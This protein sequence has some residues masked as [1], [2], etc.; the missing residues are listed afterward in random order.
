MK[1]LTDDTFVDAISAAQFAV[2]DFWAPWCGPCRMISPILEELSKVYQNISFFKV[3][4]D[5]N[6]KTASYF[7]IRSIPL[8]ILFKNG[9]PQKSILGARPKSVYVSEFNSLLG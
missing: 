9:Q 1:E 7:A 8:V 5:L 6:P 2:V 4:T 3:D